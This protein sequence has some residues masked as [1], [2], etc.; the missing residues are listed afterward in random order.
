MNL[1]LDSHAAI[2]WATG[3]AALDAT[4]VR[5]IVE[6][7]SVSVSL[8]TPWELQIKVRTGKFDLGGADW[9]EMERR[10]VA[11]LTPTLDDV[12][13]AANLPLHHRDPFDRLIVAQA[14]R[15]H[16]L[17]VTRD[18]VHSRDCVPNNPR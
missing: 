12:L 8:A 11:L 10:G 3:S 4:S 2:W 1:L 6:E 15:R 14:L 18:S 9:A 13:L 7:T 16:L 17:V 5:M